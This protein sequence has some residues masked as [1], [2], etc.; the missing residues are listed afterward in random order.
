[1]VVAVFLEYSPRGYGEVAVQDFLKKAKKYR[2]VGCTFVC[3]FSKLFG[4]MCV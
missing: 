4:V 3:R 1:M 2:N